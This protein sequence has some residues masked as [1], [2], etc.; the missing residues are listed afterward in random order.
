MIYDLRSDPHE[1][2]NLMYTEL[3]VG[4]IIAPN[5]KII[6]EYQRNLQKPEHQSWRGLPG[7]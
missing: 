3:T 7:L 1:G 4:W 6:G 2:N 5:F